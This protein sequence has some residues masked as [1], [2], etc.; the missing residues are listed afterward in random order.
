MAVPSHV[1]RADTASEDVTAPAIPHKS[2]LRLSIDLT[3]VVR[4]A[5]HRVVLQYSLA[6]SLSK[7]R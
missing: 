6:R 1:F 4:H 7:S 5:R 2:C 3:E